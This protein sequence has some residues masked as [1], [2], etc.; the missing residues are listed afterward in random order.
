MLTVGGGLLVC[1]GESV[2]HISIG[3]RPPVA[4]QALVV[5]G[6][7]LGYDLLLGMDS[8]MQLGGITVND[9]GNIRFSRREKHVCAAVTLGEPDFHAEYNRD[10]NVWTAL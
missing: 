10:T 9:T 7:L 1:C 6:E 4:I 2:D 8:I 3:N 5:D